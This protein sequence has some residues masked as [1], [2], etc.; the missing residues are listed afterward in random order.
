M[1]YAPL[2]I[3]PGWRRV[4]AML[5]A[6]SNDIHRSLP[7]LRELGSAMTGMPWANPRGLIWFR[8]A[9]TVVAWVLIVVYVHRLAH[10]Y[11]ADIGEVLNSPALQITATT[12][13]LAG[14]VC[15]VML[16]LPFLPNPGLRRV[17]MVLFWAALLVVGHSLSHMG[18]HDAQAMLETMRDAVG[19]LALVSL[20]LAY[21]LALAMPFIPGVELGLLIM[22]VFGPLG[23]LVA[24]AATI[25]GLGLAYALGRV[26]PERI[27]VRLLTRLGIAVPRDSV[28]YAM[29][30][31]IAGSGTTGSAPRR[32]AAM[33]L[34]HRY[35]TLAACL[36]FPGNAALGGG[37]GLALLCGLSRQFG[38]RA[39]LMTVAVATSPV[40]MLVLFGLLSLE[41]LME[42]HGF[43]HDALTR[44]ERLFIHD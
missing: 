41:P 26:L 11:Q 40:P 8:V 14:L 1:S 21:A 28:A 10:T 6:E 17:G 5:A 34:N 35:L 15:L 19:A 44:I 23:A 38:W 2:A 13:L 32:L 4:A 30:G 27:I 9:V 36:S 18:F 39:F 22:A 24:Y 43:L 12:L 31:M 25:G 20:A 33:L 3:A 16:S 42:H 37:G 29:Q 7:S